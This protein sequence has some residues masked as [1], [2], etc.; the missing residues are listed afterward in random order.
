MKRFLV[1]VAILAPMVAAGCG[2]PEVVAEAAITDEGTGER[3]A[4]GDLPI[5]LLPY[6]RDAVFDSLEAAH[7]EPEPPIPDEIVAQQQ[8]VQEAQTEWRL[9]E[10]RWAAVRDELRQISEQLT[11]MQNQG[12]RGT[13]QYAQAF[14]RFGTL[15][16]EERQ[17]NQQMQQAFQE[18]DQLQQQTLASAD[19]IRVVRDMWAEEAFAEFNTV[20]LQKIR[21]SGREE[22]ADTTNAQGV[23]VFEVPAGRWWL[24]GRYTLPYE[25]LY[26]NVPI[27]VTGDS[28]HVPLTR[29]NAESRPVL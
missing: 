14:E 15:E 7:S 9:A 22:H 4:L 8:Q 26:W 3:L 25:E 11:Q 1:L 21:E 12:L 2:Q 23:A 17:V 27:E 16:T 18:F 28:T 20:I 13:P 29:E 19:S 10:E 6:D 24:Y 5:R